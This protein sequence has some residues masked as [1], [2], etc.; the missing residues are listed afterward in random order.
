MATKLYKITHNSM[1]NRSST[2]ILRNVV[3]VHPRK[4]HT[5]FEANP[6]SGFSDEV[7]KV[8]DDGHS[9]RL[10][11]TRSLSVTKKCSH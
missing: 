9:D 8:Q 2:S 1:K 6:C 4:I 11:R 5:Q 7:K 3:G 10:S